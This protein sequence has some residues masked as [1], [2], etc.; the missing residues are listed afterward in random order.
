MGKI[1]GGLATSHAPQLIMP[2]LKW[3]DLPDRAKGPFHPKPG[4]EADITQEA[5]L[6]HEARCKAALKKLS[7]QLYRWSPDVIICFGDDQHENVFDD[8]Q[9]PFLIY[10]GEEADAT[11][12]FLYL[13]EKAENQMTRYKVKSDLA[14]TLVNRLM[15]HDFDPAWATKLR[16]HTGLGHAFGRPLN[17]IMPD[18]KFPI[19]PVMMNTYDQPSPSARRCYK[20]GQAVRSIVEG[21]PDDLRVVVLASGGLS[22]TIIDETF[23]HAFIKA[24]ETRDEAY[25]T[26][27]PPK[28]LVGGTSEILTWITVAGAT[29]TGMKLVDYAPCYRNAQGVGCAMGFAIWE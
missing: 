7:E 18:H 8:N 10:M 5:M 4:I 21:M 28:R 6:A 27:V 15:D 24:L 26:S 13:G 12:H 14:K 3:A 29:G 11:L 2:A 20:L 17:F 1:I 19:V 23:D 25:L 9:P 22:H 16:E